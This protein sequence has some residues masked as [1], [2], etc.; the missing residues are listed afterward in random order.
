VTPAGDTR[1]AARRR[2]SRQVRNRA[3]DDE[4][5]ATHLA[6]LLSAHG[7]RCASLNET[8]WRALILTAARSGLCGLALERVQALDCHLNQALEGTLRSHAT[9]AASEERHIVQEASGVLEALREAGAP[10]LL[11]KGCALLATVYR[12]PGLRPMGDVDLLVRPGDVDRATAAMARAGCNRGPEFVRD[13]FFPRFHYETEWITGGPRPVRIDLHVRPLRPLRAACTVP[14]DAMWRDARRVLVGSAAAWIPSPT[15][16]LIHLCAHAAYHGF[17]RLIWLYDIRRFATYFTARLDWGEFVR[18]CASWRLTLPV[19]LALERSERVLGA[20]V[21]ADVVAQLDGQPVSWR[22]RLVMWQAPRDADRPVLHVLTN[23]VTTPR[24]GL[25]LTYLA[26]CGTPSRTHLEA[27]YPWR[28]R[29]WVAVATLWRLIRAAARGLGGLVPAPI[30]R[31]EGVT[32][33]N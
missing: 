25:A 20:C 28:H 9:N 2:T 31:H 18:L 27:S 13:D 22:D 32:T 3:G 14:D 15:R 7:E 8:Q 11:L 29:G 33:G 24:G 16:M 5:G 10:A 12:A 23:T 26:A 1:I 6:L 19:R 17:A 21:P 4:S 30:R